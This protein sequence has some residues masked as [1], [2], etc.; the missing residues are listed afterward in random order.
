[1]RRVTKEQITEWTENPVTEFLLHCINERVDF[2]ESKVTDCYQPFEPQKTQE[3]LAHKAGQEQAWS[4]IIS[5]IH[6]DWSVFSQG[7]ETDDEYF[8]YLSEG[9]SGSSEA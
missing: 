7:D 2:L 9:E 1:M 5:V 4:E 8:G 6:G 3:L